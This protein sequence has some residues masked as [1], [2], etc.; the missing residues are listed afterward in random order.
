MHSGNFIVGRLV[1]EMVG[2]GI[3]KSN[4]FHTDE[5]LVRRLDRFLEV[6]S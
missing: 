1:S 5:E 6:L 4:E 3:Q 2:E